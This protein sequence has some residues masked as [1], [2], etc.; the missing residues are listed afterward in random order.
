MTTRSWR[1]LLFAP[2]QLHNIRAMVR[3]IDDMKDSPNSEVRLK[4]QNSVKY[5]EEDKDLM[6]IL[7]TGKRLHARGQPW[8]EQEKQ[9][10][11]E[12]QHTLMIGGKDRKFRHEVENQQSQNTYV[13]GH[14]MNSF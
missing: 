4:T 1:Q 13:I 5:L 7:R 8:Q 6:P 12:S 9:D 2:R 11:K 3:S 10:S 14:S